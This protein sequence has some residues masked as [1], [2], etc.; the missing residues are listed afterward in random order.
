MTRPFRFGALEVFAASGKDWADCA[1][2]VEDSGFS[3]LQTIDHLGMMWAPLPA[4]TAAAAATSTLRVG[5][6]VL[7]NDYRHP[8]Q[9][10]KEA[11]TLDLVSDGRLELGIGA[12]WM[13]TD[14]DAMGIPFDRPKVRIDR[15]EEA[16]TIIKGCFGA[17]P[18]SFKGEHYTITD[19]PGLPK[20]V[21]P[22]G[23]PLMIGGGGKRMLRIAGREADVVSLNFDLSSNALPGEPPPTVGGIMTPKI[24]ATGTAAMVDEK[25]GWV[26]EGAGA[27]FDDVELNITTFVLMITDDPQ[28]AAEGVAADLGITP[29]QVLELP[30][31]LIGSVEQ[32]ADT[33]VERR[34]R[35]G[36]S[37]ITFPMPMIPDG[38]KTLAPLVER[39]AGT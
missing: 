8:V 29:A 38:Y 19:Y 15:F 16:I 39:L 24:A 27:R 22:K 32:M 18:V 9:L 35:Y 31:A 14:Y 21:Q 25:I 13:V 12:G 26:R 30:F 10:A 36:I 23:P 17:A 5:T 33:L 11:A 28:R 20:P 7:A 1:R 34:E 2:L 37:Y 3:T 4:L 6:Q